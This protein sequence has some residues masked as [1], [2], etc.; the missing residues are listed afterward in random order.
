MRL[1]LALMPPP[2]L[3]E[4]LGELADAAHAQC[5]GRRMP[6]ETL[7]VTLAFL[8]EVTEKQAT[9][10]V[11]GVQG[12]AVEPD[13]WH[14]DRW[15]HFRQPGI[16]WVGGPSPALAALHGR[17]W[18]TLEAQGLGSRPARFIPHVT[19]LRRADSLDLAPLPRTELSWAYNQVTLIHSIR[20][21]RGARYRILAASPGEHEA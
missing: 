6:D 10:L 9:E 8:G 17:L 12:L 18:S 1:F 16:V 15:G 4:R 2:R 14:L 19:L 21:A 11:D 5:G 3:R 20:D 13:E 7:H